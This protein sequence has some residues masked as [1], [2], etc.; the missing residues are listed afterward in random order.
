MIYQFSKTLTNSD[1]N[2]KFFALSKL[3]REPF[4]TIE[5]NKDLTLEC[6]DGGNYTVEM[7]KYGRI[8]ASQFFNNHG[9]LMEGTVVNFDIDTEKS[10]VKISID[11]NEFH[12]NSNDE[13]EFTPAYEKEVRDFLSDR[14]KKGKFGTLQLYNGVQGIEYNTKD[15]GKIDILCKEENGDFVVIEI[16]KKTSSDK[17]V[18]QIQRYMGWVKENL[19]GNHDVKGIIVLHK[20]EENPELT[21]LIYAVKANPNIC[22]KFYKISISLLED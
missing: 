21:K 19:A 1:V 18:G 10:L 12:E 6:T 15:V 20:E 14:I 16:K 13:R 3:Q 7:D 2:Y 8:Y 17:V 5:R 9:W 11:Q 22:L 4:G